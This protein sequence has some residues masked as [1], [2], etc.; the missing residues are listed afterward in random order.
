MSKE[1]KVKVEDKASSEQ[2]SSDRKRAVE[3]HEEQKVK[4]ENGAE[5]ETQGGESE[6]AA[7][8]WFREEKNKEDR[9]KARGRREEGRGEGQRK[10]SKGKLRNSR[11]IK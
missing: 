10:A 7:W 2:S 3:E 11:K 6:N 5:N 1:Y 4:A 8:K 9:E